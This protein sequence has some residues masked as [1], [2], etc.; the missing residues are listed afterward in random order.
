MTNTQ[1]STPHAPQFRQAAIPTRGHANNAN[2]FSYEKTPLR[3]NLVRT[4]D[5][6]AQPV[7]PTPSRLK[8]T[9]CL[10]PWRRSHPCHTVPLSGQLAQCHKGLK[11]LISVTPSQIRFRATLCAYLAS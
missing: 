5:L 6:A 8:I 10:T 1:K 7:I 4:L 9:L 3:Y 11:S 2:N